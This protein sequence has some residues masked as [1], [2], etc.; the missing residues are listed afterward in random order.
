MCW[1]DCGQIVRIVGARRQGPRIQHGFD[2]HQHGSQLFEDP[3]EVRATWRDEAPGDSVAAAELLH[4]LDVLLLGEQLGQSLELGL[5]PNEVRRV[6]GV[7][8]VH[9]AS[10]SSKPAQGSEEGIRRQ[11]RDQFQVY[12][13]RAHT[14]EEGHVPLRHHRPS[15]CGQR[16]DQ[17]RPCEIDTGVEERRGWLNSVGREVSHQLGRLH[18]VDSEAR[19]APSNHLPDCRLHVH[20][21]KTLTN[22]REQ[23]LLAYV[24][25]LFVFV[26]N[27][28][29]CDRVLGRHQDLVPAVVRHESLL[30]S[31]ANSQK[32]VVGINE[33]VQSS[34]AVRVVFLQ[35]QQLGL[36]RFPLHQPQGQLQRR[37]ALF[38]R[39]FSLYQDFS[40]RDDVVRKPHHQ[41]HAAK[42]SA[43][44]SELVE[45]P[46]SLNRRR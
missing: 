2:L 29:F 13:S 18:R 17:E 6:V 5:R 15:C 46:Q 42:Q 7:H 23:A 40:S 33:R 45:D 4:L 20:R 11:T 14:H 21:P 19:H 38:A 37:V 28:R 32:A 35:R 30:D 9:Q 1:G 34:Q 24:E 27:E 8:F 43:E 22:Q 44:I 39:R 25:V 26:A 10:T 3:T 31:T 41:A 36:E 16:L 12:G